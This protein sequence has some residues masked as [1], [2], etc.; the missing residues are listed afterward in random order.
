MRR[1]AI[2]LLLTVP[3]ACAWL[4]PAPREFVVFFQADS[5]TLTPEAAPIVTQIAAAA[6]TSHAGSITIEGDADGA[7]E[8]DATLAIER[9]KAVANALLAAGVDATKVDVKDTA[10]LTGTPGVASHK[11]RVEVVP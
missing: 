3:G 6:K 4:A 2:L 1:V 7:T 9:S 11:V 8:R 10:A 5:A